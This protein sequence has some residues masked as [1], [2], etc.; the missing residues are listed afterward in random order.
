MLQ[1]YSSVLSQDQDGAWTYHS[2]PQDQALRGAGV[3][4]QFDGLW[5][6]LRTKTDKKEQQSYAQSIVTPT[7]DTQKLGAN[8]RIKADF[9]YLL[10]KIDLG[11]GMYPSLWKW[12]AYW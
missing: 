7:C 10:G 1:S 4:L 5:R 11:R 8:E 3:D 6:V 2:L 9:C 12:A